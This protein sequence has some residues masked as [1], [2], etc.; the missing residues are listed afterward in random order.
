MEYLQKSYFQDRFLISDVTKC[1][2][3]H[4]LMMG[5][6]VNKEFLFTLVIYYVT[7][8]EQCVITIQYIKGTNFLL[9]VIDIAN[10]GRIV[11]VSSA[12]V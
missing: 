2:G 9:K 12:Q 3:V 4:E 10:Y 5:D 11:E 6:L 8:P 7:T 1:K